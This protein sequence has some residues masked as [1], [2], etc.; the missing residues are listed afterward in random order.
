[1]VKGIDKSENVWYTIIEEYYTI[2]PYL[3]LP[4][5]LRLYGENV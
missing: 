3:E 4:L 5:P 2:I 1:M